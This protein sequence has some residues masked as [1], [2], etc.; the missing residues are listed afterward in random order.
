MNGETKVLKDGTFLYEDFEGNVPHGH[1]FYKDEL[2]AG[3]K[4]L[5]SLYQLT[6]DLDYLSDKGLI[7]ILLQKYD[8]AIKIFLE[9]EKIQPNRYSTASNLGTAYELIGQNENALKW[10]SKSVEIDP[11]SHKNSEWIHVKILEAKIKGEQ[12]YTTKFLLDSDFG[13]DTIPISDI[14]NENLQMLSDAL[15]F[16]LNERISFVKP[17]DKIVAQLLYDLGNI[18]FLL[19][20]YY[21]AREDYIMAKEYGY[22]SHII[23]IRAK[24]IEQKIEKSQSSKKSIAKKS[25]HKKEVY[26]LASV[27]LVILVIIFIRRKKL[28]SNR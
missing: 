17:K 12:F 24:K 23:E 19:G 9:I 27:I 26:I 28:K 11:K 16:Q 4:R 25:V 2:E 20:N 15:Y 14:S 18:A 8:E 13:N 5:D 3:A 22:S 10:I 21:D 6:K 7:F 1:F